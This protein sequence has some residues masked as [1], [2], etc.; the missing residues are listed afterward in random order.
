M[1]C[2]YTSGKYGMLTYRLNYICPCNNSLETNRLQVWSKWHTHSLRR[3]STVGTHSWTLGKTE[4]A[5]VQELT[6]HNRQSAWQ[7]QWKIQC[8]N[9]TMQRSHEFLWMR[10]LISRCLLLVCMWYIISS[11]RRIWTECDSKRAA[12]AAA[13]LQQRRDLPR[14]GPVEVVAVM[15]LSNLQMTRCNSPSVRLPAPPPDGLWSHCRRDVILVSDSVGED[16]RSMLPLSWRCCFID[17]QWRR[18]EFECGEGAPVQSKSVG[19]P[20]RR[21]APE[22]N[23]FFWSCPSTF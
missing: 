16:G 22:K 18:N 23:V 5:W 3:F 17:S 11:S 8:N 13:A 2:I 10:K 19:A 12:S 1:W 20:V 7:W 14:V 21:E 15:M 4:P 9:A 6:D